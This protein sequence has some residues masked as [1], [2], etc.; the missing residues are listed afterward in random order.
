MYQSTS[1]K[2]QK[3][4]QWLIAACCV[5][6]A[7]LQPLQ[8]AAQNEPSLS[9]PLTDPGTWEVF[10]R[11]KGEYYNME[12]YPCEGLIRFVVYIKDADAPN[13]DNELTAMAFG[14]G[15]YEILKMD[16]N[17]TL[18]S[19]ETGIDNGQTYRGGVFD[20]PSGDSFSVAQFPGVTNVRVETVNGRSNIT[21]LRWDWHIPTEFYGDLS[22]PLSF[23]VYWSNG[24]STSQNTVQLPDLS[25]PLMGPMSPPSA[26]PLTNTRGFNVTWDAFADCLGSSE[27]NVTLS[28]YR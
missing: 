5:F 25:F 19:A 23:N 11:T 20:H 22:V 18:W 15:S 16:D 21:V 4:R 24:S 27:S 3:V 10:T 14:H 17:A 26:T 2:H 8:V 1:M 28:L 7:W 9:V 6:C 12:Y 13:N